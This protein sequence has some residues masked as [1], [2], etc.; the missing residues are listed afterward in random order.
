MGNYLR[1]LEI[2][3]APFTGAWIETP[4]LRTRRMMRTSHPSRVRGLKHLNGEPTVGTFDIAPFTGAWIETDCR[5]SPRRFDRIAPFT[6]AWIETRP[7]L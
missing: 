3:I 6:G 7:T 5:G 1:V 2:R 4:R